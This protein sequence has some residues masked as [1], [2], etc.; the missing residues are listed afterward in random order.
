M[1]IPKLDLPVA[2]TGLQ[3]DP[4]SVDLL[5]HNDEAV[6][7]LLDEEVSNDPAVDIL[8]NSK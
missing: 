5:V 7:S 4:R 1:G 2:G 8:L 6:R 3:V